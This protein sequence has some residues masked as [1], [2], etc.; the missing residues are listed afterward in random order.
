M[1]D[2]KNIVAT[3]A[4][5][6]ATALG[7]PLAGLG[8]SAIGKALGL[9]DGSNE[10]D[11]AAAVLRASPDQLL[12]IKRA[13]LEFTTK[14]KELDVD[15]ERIAMADRASARKREAATGDSWTPR[16]LAI[17]VIGLFGFCVWWAFSGDVAAMDAAQIGIIGGVIG[18]A[19]AKADTVVGYYFGSSVGTPLTANKPVARR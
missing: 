11:V 1:A 9:G 2:W 7:G 4:P 6:I 3:V 15:L 17:L 13:E 5:A 18:Y 14:I 10:D 8:V 12:A 19:S 16:L